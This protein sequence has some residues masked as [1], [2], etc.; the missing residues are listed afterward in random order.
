VGVEVRRFRQ[1]PSRLRR[2]RYGAPNE[3]DLRVY[4]LVT[5][6]QGKRKRLSFRVKISPRMMRYRRN[7]MNLV[8]AT[9]NAIKD[10]TIPVHKQGEV[11]SGFGE[12]FEETKWVKVRKLHWYEA[13][14]HYER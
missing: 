2:M 10:K 4:G 13:G 1:L 5:T 7:L 9:V 8:R 12:L 6:M 3:G 14:V 11:F